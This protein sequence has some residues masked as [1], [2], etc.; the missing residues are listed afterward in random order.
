MPFHVKKTVSFFNT[1]NELYWRA[2]DFR[3]NIKI[4]RTQGRETL[5]IWFFYVSLKKKGMPFNVKKTV[6]FFNTKNKCNWQ[7]GCFWSNNANVWTQGQM[8]FICCFYYCS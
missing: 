8:G 5:K 2:C 7:R 6:F 1:T 4:G 3:S